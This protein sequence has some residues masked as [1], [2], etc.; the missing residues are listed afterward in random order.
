M[1]NITFVT[2]NKNKLKEV[3][4]ILGIKLNHQ[5]IDLHEIQEVSVEC[6]VEH[7]AKKA[8]EIIQKPVVVEDAGFCFDAFNG[9]PGALIK[10]VLKYLGRENIC[11]ML[12]EFDRSA[13]AMCAVGYY[14]GKNFQAF[15][16]EIKGKIAETPKGDSKFGFDPLFIP[17]G[18]KKTF[19]EM[20]SEEKNKI[21]HR[22]KAWTKFKKFLEQL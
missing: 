4:E 1:K 17:E 7:K 10:W 8:Y 16:G 5:D 9:F 19:A 13:K 3:E 2:G 11:K 15:V 21:S 12:N 6:V 22:S 20:S 14:D 18:Q